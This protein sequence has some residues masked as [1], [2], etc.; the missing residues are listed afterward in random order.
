MFFFFFPH[1]FWNILALNP[2][3]KH[4]KKKKGGGGGGA[5]K[6]PKHFKSLYKRSSYKTIGY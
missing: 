4:K 2:K 1:L 5:I 3:N 6:G